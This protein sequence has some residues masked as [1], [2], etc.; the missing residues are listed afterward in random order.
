MSAL[1]A[2][3]SEKM[4]VEE[5]GQWLVENGFSEDICQCFEHK[6]ADFKLM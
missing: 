4:T 6:L 3:L 5:L 2:S 1:S